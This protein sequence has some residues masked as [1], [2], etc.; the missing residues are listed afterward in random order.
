MLDLQLI[1][2]RPKFVKE[3]IAR[4]GAEAPIDEI[5]EL[6]QQRRSILTEVEGLRSERN[7]GSKKIGQAAAGAEREAAIAEM[8]EIGDRI[9]SLDE[10]LRVVDEQLRAAMLVVPNLPDPDVP[11]GKDESENVI[12]GDW[13]TPREFDFDPRPHWEIGTDLDIIDFERGVKIAGS[14]FYLLKGDGARLQRA[15]ITWFLDLHMQEHGFTEIYPP[16]MVNSKALLGTGNLPKFADNQYRIEGEDYWLIPTAEV[17]VTNMYGDEILDGSQLPIYHCAYSPC[18][19]REQFSAGRD[20]RGIKRVHQFD[21]VELVKFVHPDTSND[22]LMK[23]VDTGAVVLEKLEIPYRRL[24]MCTG[25]LSFVAAKKIDLEAWAPGCEEWLE[26]SSCSNF[27]DF[28]ARRAQIRFRPEEGKRT[29]F[30]HTL[31]GSALALPRTMIA[32]IEN[33]QQADG[34]IAVP[35][36]LRPYM[37]GQEVIGK[38]GD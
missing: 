30:V 29:E 27:R 13:G 6:D 31:N 21:K 19:R 22:E 12:I 9:Q 34:S 8:R 18:F 3:Q 25:D 37:G 2:E 36:V 11:D 17:P 5:L 33:Y 26:V 4:L 16:V 23:L 32:V 28:Q 24:Q 14:R 15:L 1:R 20:V 35:E 7:A 38:S 10:Q